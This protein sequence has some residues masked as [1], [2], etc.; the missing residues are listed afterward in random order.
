MLLSRDHLLDSINRMKKI[1]SGCINSDNIIFHPTDTYLNMSISSQN[2]RVISRLSSPAEYKAAENVYVTTSLGQF[3]SIVSAFPKGDTINIAFLSGKL[4]I[5]TEERQ[6]TVGSRSLP[7]DHWKHAEDVDVSEQK[8]VCIGS[9]RPEMLKVIANTIEGIRS[10]GT[11]ED[12]KVMLAFEEGKFTSLLT[13]GYVA[14]M[15]QAEDNTITKEYTLET[16]SSAIPNMLSHFGNMEE[17]PVSLWVSDK[18]VRIVG[19]Q[20]TAT[21]T[22]A[23]A[24]KV[25]G[26]SMVTKMLDL[27]EEKSASIAIKNEA[28]IDEAQRASVIAG[29]DGDTKIL[30]NSERIGIVSRGDHGSYVASLENGFTLEGQETNLSLSPILLRR[31]TNASKAISN[32][33]EIHF[34]IHNIDER[35]AY[36]RLECPGPPESGAT[37]N[38]LFKFKK[39]AKTE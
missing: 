12:Y 26:A 9:I 10:V 28:A 22:Y 25:R 2:G 16:T 18:M 21:V 20:E 30:V 11:D 15:I 29:K 4:K 39:E 7:K 13:A 5:S 27:L 19:S 37:V 33:D 3:M 1:A 34:N 24:K 35:S 38:M 14:G 31:L 17:S 36:C 6:Y 8:M 32:T 23:R